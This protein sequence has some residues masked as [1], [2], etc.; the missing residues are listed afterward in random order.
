M[1][2]DEGFIWEILLDTEACDGDKYALF[3]RNY[4]DKGEGFISH[5][6]ELMKDAGLI[7]YNQGPLFDLIYDGELGRS[8]FV[9]L[10]SKGHDTLAEGR[11]SIVNKSLGHALP[12]CKNVINSII[13][14]V[15]TNAL[16]PLPT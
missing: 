11:K 13:A 14:A 7:K 1:K 9:E 3:I 5:H 12:M 8:F 15:I 6:L 4:C 2:R 10:T 16:N